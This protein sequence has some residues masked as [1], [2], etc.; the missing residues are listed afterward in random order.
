MRS[1]SDT[2]F[3]L[4]DD[5]HATA[6]RPTSRLFTGFERELSCADPLRLAEWAEQLQVAQRAGLHAVLLADY[7]WGVRLAGLSATHAEQG[8]LSALLFRDCRKLAADEVSAWLAAQEG[9][10]QAA[11]VAISG[12]EPSIDGDVFDAHIKAIQKAIREGETYQVNFTYRLNGQLAG[13]PLALYRRLR[14]R[15]PVA[16]GA[17]IALPA[18]WQY[19]H[20]LSFSPE[21]FLR[22]EEGVLTAKPMKG[23]AP[24]QSDVASDLLAREQ[25]ANPKNRAENLMIVDLLRN[26]LGRVA[27]IGSV[28]VPALFDIEAH[29]TVWQ[30]TSTISA[31]LASGVGLADLLRALFPCGSITGAP[32]RNTMRLIESLEDSPRGIYCGL[33][34]WI[35]QRHPDAAAGCG[36]FCF[37]VP[38]RTLTLGPP[39]AGWR[40]LRLGIGAGIVADSEATQ[41][42]A[43]CALKARFL[44]EMATG[45]ALI[46]TMRVERRAI[47][48]LERHLARLTHSAEALG[49]RIE[50]PAIRREIE[51]KL[52][53]VPESPHRLR[54]QLFP[55]GR[56]ELE[57]S[58]LES[59]PTEPVPLMVAQSPLASDRWVLAHKTSVRAPYE[60]ALQRALAKAA[61]DELQFNA[62]G[63]LTEG[64]RSN[65]FLKIAGKWLTPALA[66]GVL[67]GVMRG[68]L[69][70]DPAWVAREA[71]LSVAD[72]QGADEI[73]VCNALRG[74]LRG[75]LIQ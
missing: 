49:F 66:C 34:G 5:C 63:E 65:V 23:T 36:D 19:E 67:P 42:H 59:T 33:I 1:S 61:F 37:S 58:S 45:Y 13:S 22:N 43:E 31:R 12:L 16:Y 10:A 64:A 27:Q 54:L 60:Q 2:V 56:L 72:L 24:R 46:E 25:L 3:A 55:N 53:G 9:S 15:Q 75:R 30:M 28:N 62:A 20:L 50:V 29:P 39:A 6:Q 70:D 32:K 7:E 26:D 8:C 14:Q 35:D 71:H 18:D 73:V 52:A 38:I 74:V 68:V 21:L 69:L 4:L 11:A 51:S 48:L 41:E 47:A 17:L 44:I 40:G 57:M